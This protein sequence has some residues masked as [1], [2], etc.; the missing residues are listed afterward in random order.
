[1]PPES[2]PIATAVPAWAP[3]HPLLAEHAA[4]LAFSM[5]LPGWQEVPQTQAAMRVLAHALALRLSLRPDLSLGLDTDR[6]QATAPESSAEVE[7]ALARASQAAVP[8]RFW[9]G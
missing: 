4:R 3:P 5:R 1:M 7:A 9:F 2:P 8:D 6:L